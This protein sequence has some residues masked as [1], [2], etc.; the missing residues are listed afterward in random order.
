MYSI[1]VLFK[2]S[3]IL[4]QLFLLLFRVHP[5]MASRASIHTCA[6]LVY[7]MEGRSPAARDIRGGFRKELSPSFSGFITAAR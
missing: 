1:L 6:A 5:I 3:L 7:T 4:H 2:I